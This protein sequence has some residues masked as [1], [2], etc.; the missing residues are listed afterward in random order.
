MSV[1]LSDRGTLLVPVAHEALPLPDTLT[2]GARAFVRKREHHITV[3]GFDIGRV[4]AP[5]I[6]DVRAAIDELAA[7]TDF[8]FAT[9]S[10][11]YQL[12]RDKPRELE[13][14]VMLVDAPGIA[15]FFARCAARLPELAPSLSSA[16]WR[17]P[18]PHITCFTSDPKGVDG[19][20]LRLPDE[21]EAAQQRAREGERSGL[22]AF[23]LS[24]SVMP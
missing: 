12:A 7:A 18:P 22:R 24:P 17:P 2:L 8:G 10:R 23:L 4:I 16:D 1:S 13:T 5:C 20:G 21:L 3:F 19:I 6:A 14:V 15:E 11:W 9:T